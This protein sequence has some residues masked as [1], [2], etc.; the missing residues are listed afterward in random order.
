MKAVN[1]TRNREVSGDVTVAESLYRRMKGLLGRERLCDGESLLIRPCS[2]IHTIGM[3]FPIDV[4]FLD[5]RNVVIAL[6]KDLPPCRLTR[7]YFRSASVL[8]L[9]AGMILLTHT[10][11]GDEIKIA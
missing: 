9:Q 3:K 1:I 10:R 8:E 4:L 2:S 6:K 5:K 7:I 11:I